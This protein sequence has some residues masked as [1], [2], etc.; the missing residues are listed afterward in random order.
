MSGQRPSRVKPAAAAGSP[1][2]AG[3]GEFPGPPG[4]QFGVGS[5]FL[6]GE[7]GRRQEKDQAGQEPHIGT[8][9]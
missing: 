2:A 8:S 5:A 3:Q 7:E 9:L 6:L 1:L 4:D